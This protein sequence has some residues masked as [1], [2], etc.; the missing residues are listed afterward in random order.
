M[1]QD[2][3]SARTTNSE[4][5]VSASRKPITSGSAFV[6]GFGSVQSKILESHIAANRR[7]LER[8]HAEVDG[9]VDVAAESTTHS[10]TAVAF[11]DDGSSL[12][13]EVALAD[14]LNFV[15]AGIKLLVDGIERAKLAEAQSESEM[16]S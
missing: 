6:S 5:A 11:Q 15:E 10:E 14:S 16:T 13:A 4:P 2:N 8:F 9:A 3:P 7:W 1:L 12:D